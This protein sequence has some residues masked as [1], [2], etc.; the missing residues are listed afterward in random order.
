MLEASRARVTPFHRRRLSLRLTCEVVAELR[1]RVVQLVRRDVRIAADRGEIGVPEVLRHESGIASRL[2]K[3]RC[4]GV[5]ECVRRDVLFE[6][7]ARR[8]CG[9]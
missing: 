7:G 2:P 1:R 3:P 8:R 6:S 5:P 9:R 4:C